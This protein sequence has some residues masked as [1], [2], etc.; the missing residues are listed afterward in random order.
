MPPLH[1]AIVDDEEL[2]RARL[3]RLLAAHDS[4]GTM[5]EFDN[6]DDLLARSATAAFD[7]VFLDVDMPERDGLDVAAQL[8]ART[9]VVFVTAYPEHALQAFDLA[10]VDYL[11]KPVLPERLAETLARLAAPAAVAPPAK[12]YPTRIAIPVGRR[13]QLVD[14]NSID[15]VIAQANY[16]DIRA[17]GRTFVLRSPLHKFACELDPARFQRVHRSVVVRLDAVA[18]V[19]PLPA[20]RFRLRLKDGEAVMS[21]RSYRQRVRRAFGLKA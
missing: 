9:R 11:V 4:V 10:A 14:V 5:E 20:G 7:A 19:E 12:T 21:G 1:V 16:I 8:R 15:C 6:G 2:A 17:G 18:H 3:R 13:V